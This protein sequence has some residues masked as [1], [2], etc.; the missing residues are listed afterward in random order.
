[1][2]FLTKIRNKFIFRVLAVCFSATFAGPTLAQTADIEDLPPELRALI[3]SIVTAPKSSP[4]TSFGSPVGFGAQMGDVFTGLSLTTLGPGQSNGDGVVSDNL[5]GSGSIG[6]G[7]GNSSTA[8]GVEIVANIISLNDSFAEDGNLSL[9]LH[10]RIGSRGSVALGVEST[11][12]WGGAK[13][14]DESYYASYSYYGTLTPDNPMNPH[15]FMITGGIGDNRFVK[16]S[17]NDD[18]APFVSAGF[19]I[20]RRMSVIAD[21]SAEKVNLGISFVPIVALPITILLGAV[22]VTEEDADTEA[23]ISAGFSFN[24][25]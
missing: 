25:N 2:S 19:N 24:F 8:I 20:N 11:A 7:L 5:D 4:G 1:M 16:T 23:T 12:G 13:N 21:Y 6:F 17:S 15:G 18:F 22:D 3:Q 10:R 9:K 14:V